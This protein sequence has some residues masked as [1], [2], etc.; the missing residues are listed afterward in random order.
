M[1]GLKHRTTAVLKPVENREL[2]ERLYLRT[3]HLVLVLVIVL[4]GKISRTRTITR[5]INDLP[6]SNSWIVNFRVKITLATR[7]ETRSAL[8]QRSFRLGNDQVQGLGGE[9]QI[10]ISRVTSPVFSTP[11]SHQGGK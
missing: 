6:N 5:T 9:V 4:E 8:R 10:R 1:F 3:L 11:C 7:P 2:V